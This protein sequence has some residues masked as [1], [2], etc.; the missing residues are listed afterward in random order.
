[1]RLL[2]INPNTNPV[3]TSRIAA[4]AASAAAPETEISAV[5]ASSGI[6]AIETPAQS[7]VAAAAVLRLVKAQAGD[8]DAT[9]IAA[10]SDPGLAEARAALVQPV[11]GIAESAM[12]HAATIAA[13]F[14]IITLGEAFRDLLWAHAETCGVRGQLAAIRFLPWRVAEVG[15]S[16]DRYLDAFRRECIRTIEDD[17]AGAIVIG[18]GPLSGMA[19]KIAGRIPAPVLDGVVCAVQ[20][21]ERMIRA[22]C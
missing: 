5:S 3:T 6:P 20:R 14:S 17:D 15:A 16:P 18:G 2:I 7:A 4:I 9:I 10:F 11:I 12:L 21:A 22:A 1:M 8:H 19:G 13:R